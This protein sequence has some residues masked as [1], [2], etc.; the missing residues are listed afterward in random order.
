MWLLYVQQV[1]GTGADTY[2]RGFRTQWLTLAPGWDAAYG[3]FLKG[4]APLVW[5]YVTSE[6][7]HREHGDSEGRYRAV[8]F[9]EGQPLQIEGASLIRGSFGKDRKGAEASLARARAFLEFLISE[10]AQRRLPLKN[11]MMPARRDTPLPASFAGLPK[12]RKLLRIEK[13]SALDVERELERWAERLRKG[14]R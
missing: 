4:E 12:P 11:W 9:D 1:L 2:W 14:S 7:Y 10:E 3:L 8:I 5:S 6:A 13:T